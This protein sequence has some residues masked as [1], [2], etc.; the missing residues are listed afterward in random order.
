MWSKELEDLTTY[1]A[2]QVSETAQALTKCALEQ[3]P[4]KILAAQE[5]LSRKRGQE[6]L[7]LT[8]LSE[9]VDVS[10]VPHLSHCS[11]LYNIQTPPKKESAFGLSE[12]SRH[13]LSLRHVSSFASE[14]TCETQESIGHYSREE[15]YF[16]SKEMASKCEGI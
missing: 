10:F 16:S 8:S 3:F 14:S 4:D 12:T 2:S 7:S 11:R 15:T 5:Y 13:E 1:T 6:E 9:K